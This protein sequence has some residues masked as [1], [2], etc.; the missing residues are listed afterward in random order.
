MTASRAAAAQAGVDPRGVRPDRSW[1]SGTE[2]QPRSDSV[3]A[4]TASLSHPGLHEQSAGAAASGCGEA[5]LEQLMSRSGFH[6]VLLAGSR[7]PNAKLTLM[8]IDGFGPAFAVK[9][10]TTPRSAEVV[11]A[12]GA[13]LHELHSLG[14]GALGGTIPRPVGFVDADGLPALVT[15]GLTGTPLT[16]GYHEWRHTARRRRVRA[17]FDAAGRWLSRLRRQTASEPSPVTFF[18]E[19]LDRI[20]DRFG[21]Q[22]VLRARLAPFTELLAKQAT[23]R[24]V[25]HGDYWFGNVLLD[26]GVVSGVV[27]WEASTLSGEPLRDVARFAVS[28]S[29]YLDRHVRPGARLPGHPGVRVGTWGVGA[30][31]AINGRGWYPDTV[32]AFCRA[33]LIEL[34]ADSG[35]ARAVLLAGIAEVAAT[36]D[37]PDF[38]RAHL[39]LLA[40]LTDDPA[41][42]DS[43]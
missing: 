3:A 30:L 26:A 35:C 43:R 11:R 28:Y 29:L 10:A 8:L 37:H 38:A 21:A 25:V 41:G 6:P 17:D 13:L 5:T 18:S 24:T 16:V 4:V 2:Q 34:G 19:S 40:R 14:L 27:D 12:E 31:H 39:E 33:A 20:E 1:L 36:A 9:V 32:Q 42:G 23:A 7:D 15:G 22:P